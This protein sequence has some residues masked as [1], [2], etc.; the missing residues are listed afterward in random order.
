MGDEKRVGVAEEGFRGKEGVDVDDD[1][2][3][4][5]DDDESCRETNKVGLMNCG[6]PSLEVEL[7]GGKLCG[8]REGRRGWRRWV[9]KNAE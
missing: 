3:D 6:R 2:D 1:D 4:D 8:P 5:D 7:Q 9:V